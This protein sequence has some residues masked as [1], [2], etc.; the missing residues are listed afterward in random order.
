[1]QFLLNYSSISKN[2]FELSKHFF[3]NSSF[4]KLSYRLHIFPIFYL[5]MKGDK[6]ESSFQN[7]FVFAFQK[8]KY[9]SFF[10]AHFLHFITCA[11]Y[12][13]FCSNEYKRIL[14]NIMT[15]NFVSRERTLNQF[16]YAIKVTHIIFSLWYE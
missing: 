1:M 2:F 5:V 9:F 10:M 15:L 6:H 14:L 16:W 12:L 3:T 8:L 11:I 4:R 7:K 13:G